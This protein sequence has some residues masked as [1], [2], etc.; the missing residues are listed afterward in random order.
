MTANHM[1]YPDFKN[2]LLTQI[3]REFSPDYDIRISSILKTNAV[4]LDSLMI[5]AP[6][7]N[8]TPNIYLNYYY[9]R[10]EKGLSFDAIFREI[11]ACYQ[12]RRTDPPFDVERFADFAYIRHHL[13][14]RLLKQSDNQNLLLDIPHIDFLDLA[15][16]FAILLEDQEGHH[17]SVL[18]H[19]SHLKAWGN[20]TMQDLLAIAK[21]NTPRLLP[22]TFEPMEELLDQ[23]PAPEGKGQSD[24][25]SSSC[26]DDPLAPSCLDSD[27]LASPPLFVLGNQARLYGAATI[28]YPEL[29]SDIAGKLS[30]DLIVI[31]SSIHEVLITPY[32]SLMCQK[33]LDDMVI[34]VNTAQVPREDILSDHVYFFS[35][36]QGHLCLT[37]P[38]GNQE[39]SEALRQEEERM[40]IVPA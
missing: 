22:Y 14:F 17:A 4:T 35:R 28:L 27:Q 24:P 7:C 39:E 6:D 18:I 13:V 1:S 23:A 9:E 37:F 20:P 30:C 32:T 15:I 2:E 33:S 26:P 21:F 12:K 31:P 11:L 38:D 16:V 25:L 10:Y 40:T 19:K 29:L 36:E 8:L 3:R 5:Y 34:Q